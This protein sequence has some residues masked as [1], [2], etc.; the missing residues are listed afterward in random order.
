MAAVLEAEHVGCPVCAGHGVVRGRA[1][2]RGGRSR[3][4]CGLCEGTGHVSRSR[5]EVLHDLRLQMQRVADFMQAGNADAAAEACRVAVRLAHSM[6]R[7]KPVLE[8]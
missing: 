1:L 6:M 7:G 4:D 3:Y 5:V 2:H 8:E